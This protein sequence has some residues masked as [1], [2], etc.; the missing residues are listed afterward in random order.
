MT[1]SVARGLRR[2]VVVMAV[3]AGCAAVFVP[4]AA[5]AQVQPVTAYFAVVQADD[6]PLRCGNNEIMYPVARLTKGTLVRVD[7]EGNKWLRVAYPPGVVACIGADS[8][9]LDAT[10]KAGTLT[11]ESRLKAFNIA[12]GYRGSWNII[13]DAPLPPGAKVTLA[14]TEP[15]NDGRGNAGYKIVPPEQARAYLPDSTVVKATQA[16]IDSYMAS[17][18]PKAGEKSAEK[19]GEKVATKPEAEKPVEKS[20]DKP[21]DRP[22][23]KPLAQQSPSSTPD[24]NAPKVV[25]EQS[26]SQWERLESA[27]EA[28]RKQPTESAEFTALIGEFQS[29]VDKLGDEPQNQSVRRRLS[30]RLEYLKLQIDIQAGARK[31]AEARQNLNAEERNLADRMKEVEKTRQYTIV[32]RLSASTIYDGK[33]LPLMY[34][35]M[36]I[37]GQSSRTLAYL[38]PDEK[39]KIDSKLGYVVGILGESRL[40]P[41]LKSNVITPV[42]VDTLEAAPATPPASTE[43]APAPATTEVPTTPGGGN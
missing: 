26:K 42:R 5:L 28:V 15:V 25:V 36:A 16:Q 7:G 31:V 6:T 23:D 21:V 12:T 13:L 19:P 27:F 4:S 20:G 43:P 8:I 18:T 38:K 17:L 32:G 14:E 41:T 2:A 3:A 29:A 37:G 9:Q 35:V 40:D 10:G 1:V 39:L 24:T 11:K 33:R 30:Q 34:R 22:A